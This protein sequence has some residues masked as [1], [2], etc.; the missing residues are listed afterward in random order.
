MTRSSSRASATPSLPS[1]HVERA[2]QQ[3]LLSLRGEGLAGMADA[4]SLT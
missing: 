3:L 4:A 1:G 2:M